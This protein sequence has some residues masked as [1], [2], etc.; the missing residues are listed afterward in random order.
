MGVGAAFGRKSA[1][2]T[3]KLKYLNLLFARSSLSD[4]QWATVA[5][6]KK[7]GLEM[8]LT[9]S[10]TQV[11]CGPEITK[12]WGLDGPQP[13]QNPSKMVGRFVPHHFGYVLKRFRTI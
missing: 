1:K 9:G 6:K 4:R 5:V 13:L 8:G 10:R 2:N 3:E 12:F 7:V 11:V